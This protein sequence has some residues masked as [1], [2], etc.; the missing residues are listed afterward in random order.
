[1]EKD[2]TKIINS[3][4]LSTVYTGEV[5]GDATQLVQINYNNLANENELFLLVKD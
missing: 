1:M 5:N 2:V 3:K 4:A